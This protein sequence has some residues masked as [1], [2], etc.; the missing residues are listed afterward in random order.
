MAMT[1]DCKGRRSS[2]WCHRR[3][4]QA[5]SPAPTFESAAYQDYNGFVPEEM[6]A[7]HMAVEQIAGEALALPSEVRRG[8]VKTVSAEEAFAQ[9]RQAITR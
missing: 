8:E 3:V 4:S 6:R 5:V 2:P 1:R 9:V 7:M